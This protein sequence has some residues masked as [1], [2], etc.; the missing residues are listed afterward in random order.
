MDPMTIVEWQQAYPALKWMI[1][2]V[3]YWSF[4]LFYI[5]AEVGGTALLSLSFWQFANQICKTSEAKRFYSFFGIVA[6]FAMFASGALGIIFSDMRDHVPEGVDPWE[7]SLKWLMGLCVISGVMTMLLY[8]WIYTNI[9]TDQR[10]YDK[11]HLPGVQPAGEGK[12]KKAK[13]SLTQ[14]FKVILSSPHVGLIAML[15]IAYGISVNL[16]EANWKKQLQLKFGKGSGEYNDFMSRVTIGTGIGA[17]VMLILGGNVMRVFSWLIAAMFTPIVMTIGGGI[18]FTF[19]IFSNQLEGWLAS[20]GTTPLGV[21]VM[22]GAVIVIAAKA[23]KYAFFDLTKEMA[24]IPLD[25][26]LKVQGKAAAEVIGG[27]LGK[28]GGAGFQVFL[29]TVF[30]GKEFIQLAPVISAFFMAICAIWA[31][32]VVGLSKR[33]E[34]ARSLR[35]AEDMKKPDEK[36]ALV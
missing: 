4:S 5:L 19:V 23:T 31:L 32:C 33:V 10:F 30:V 17:T 3:G 8:R 11:P 16:I 27:R 20:Y 1:A 28:A 34:E 29:L 7:L 21:A 13:P 6:Q 26:Q 2:I 24:Y 18:F 12:A 9:L 14:S 15:I 22:L 25:E 36:T 35:E